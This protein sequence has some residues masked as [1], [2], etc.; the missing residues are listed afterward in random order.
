MGERRAGHGEDETAWELDRR[1][2]RRRG[3]TARVYDGVNHGE[4]GYGVG[5]GWRGG[6]TWRRGVAAWLRW[7]RARVLIDF[8]RKKMEEICLNTATL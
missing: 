6:V 1:R 4:E 8:M 7:R 2:R 5:V 3:L